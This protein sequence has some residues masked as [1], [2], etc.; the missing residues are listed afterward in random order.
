MAITTYS[1]LVTALDG[2]D[3]YLH[4]TNL[5]AKIPDFVRLCEAELNTE[6]N[7]LLQEQE[8]P[9][10][11]TTGLRTIAV[12]AD[13]G[14]PL[15]LW[16]ATYQPRLQL[17]YRL[18]TTIPVTQD[19]GFSDYYT[20]DGA[21]IATENPADQA[22]SYTLRYLQT[23][24]LASTSTNVV[25]TNFPSIYLYGTLIQSVPYTRK[26]E[27]AEAWGGLYKSAIEKAKTFATKTR[28]KQTLQME[29]VGW[30]RSKIERGY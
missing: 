21:N 26:W 19:R 14:S 22:Y 3:G 25:L 2:A 4:Q 27:L 13:F 29:R 23:F 11:A 6:L 12:P 30:A 1:E 10:T 16:N 17:V 18:P 15:E 5:T 9:L 28:S 8:V 20:I 24:N 7:L